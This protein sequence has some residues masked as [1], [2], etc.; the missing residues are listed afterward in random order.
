MA[1][2][3]R[4]LL[5]RLGFLEAPVQQIEYT[6]TFSAPAPS[7]PSVVRDHMAIRQAYESAAAVSDHAD[8]NAPIQTTTQP[9]VSSGVAEVQVPNAAPG[10]EVSPILQTVTGGSEVPVHPQ[11]QNLQVVSKDQPYGWNNPAWRNQPGWWNVNPGPDGGGVPVSQKIMPT[12]T[13]AMAIGVGAGVLGA[14]Y[15]G[16]YAAQAIADGIEAAKEPATQVASGVAAVSPMGITYNVA[17]AAGQ[18]APANTI[19]GQRATVQADFVHGVDDVAGIRPVLPDLPPTPY[20]PPPSAVPFDPLV[21]PDTFDPDAPIVDWVSPTADFSP[22]AHL[23]PNVIDNYEHVDS[24]AGVFPS[25]YDAE[26]ARQKGPA[27]DI[28]HTANP[29]P[30]GVGD[31]EYSVAE[32]DSIDNFN[33]GTLEFNPTF[34]QGTKFG[35]SAGAGVLGGVVANQLGPD[36]NRVERGTVSSAV[37]ETSKTVGHAGVDLITSGMTAAGNTLAHGGI[38]IP[39]A[40]AGGAVGGAVTD[41]LE[42]SVATP[43]AEYVGDLAGTGVESAVVGTGAAVVTAATGGTTAAS[44]Q[45]AAVAAASTAG[46]GIVVA[47]TAA[48]VSTNTYLS[49]RV[50]EEVSGRQSLPVIRTATS[51]GGGTSL[52]LDPSGVR[53]GFEV[54]IQGEHVDPYTGFKYYDEWQY[55]NVHIARTHAGDVR[56]VFFDDRGE[57][58]RIGEDIVEQEYQTESGETRGG[59]KAMGAT[60]PAACVV[61]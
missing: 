25:N 22:T 7:T 47:N 39:A 56:A 55:E 54:Q 21:G 9:E 52:L 24:G 35:I 34:V 58:M 6:R 57:R 42:P 60:Q 17:Q 28:T 13:E 44:V 53:G 11:S 30:P 23:R 20:I 59:S 61:M 33:R 14:G 51:S 29:L 18:M 5:I 1:D 41:A 36:A 46:V 32:L 19:A 15:A 37:R 12:R 16:L 49:E 38:N 10:E 31:Q 27:T 43:A 50:W 40:V 8:A 48:V 45:S 2:L 3:L 4:E 26:W